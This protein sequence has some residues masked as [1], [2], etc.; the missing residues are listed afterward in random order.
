MKRE[1][2]CTAANALWMLSCVPES[3]AFRRATLNVRGTQWRLLSRVLQQNAGTEYGQRFGFASIRSVADYQARVPLTTYEAYRDAVERIGVGEKGILTSEAVRLF[4]PTSGSTAATKFIPYTATL[5]AEFQRAIAPW[6]VD[7]F[8]HEPRLLRG[9]AYWSISPVTRADERTPGGIPIGFEED[10]EYLGRWQSALIRSFQVVPSEVRWI[11]DMEAFR[12]VTLLFLLRSRSLALISVWNPTFLT[13]LVDHLADWWMPLARDIERGTLSPPTSIDGDLHES[14]RSAN[15]ADPQR[16][17]EIRTIFSAD[18]PAG[19]IHTRLWPNLRL[20]S[21]WADGHAA[22]YVPEVARHF[23]QVRIQGKGVIATEGFVSFPLIGYPGAAL[24]IR[25]HFFEFLPEEEL[26]IEG[27]VPL[28]AHELERDS[29]YSIILTTG[30]GLYRYR[31]Q[32]LVEVVGHLGECPLLRF[33]GKEALVSDRFGEKVNERH[34]RHALDTLFAHHGLHPTFAML[35]CTAE[36]NRH[37][38]TLFIEVDGVPDARLAPLAEELE[39][40]LV[41]N[42]HYRYCRDLEQLAPVRLFRIASHAWET[43]LSVCRAEGQRAGDIK[44]VALHRWGGWPEVFRQEVI[45]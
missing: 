36:R 14:L 28:L 6:I 24:A 29:V 25:S 4:E 23:P 40:A 27:S 13:L 45:R 15:D 7:L 38:Y 5:Q 16:A 44:P 10:S 11:H 30:G 3:L 1:L 31:L 9:E 22:T 19:T 37:A 26:E 41:E 33:V 42:F 12:Y 20:I 39:A 35:A 17:A 32:D 43:Y 8:R 21:C 2:L 18:A 34:V